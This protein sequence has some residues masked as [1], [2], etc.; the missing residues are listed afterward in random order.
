ML[1]RSSEI[2]WRLKK[3][4]REWKVNRRSHQEF[5]G[6]K[7]RCREDRKRCVAKENLLVKEKDDISMD[8]EVVGPLM[9]TACMS[10][11]LA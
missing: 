7:K 8:D 6:K 4:K 9:W 2:L 10:R 5:S 11:E 1:F 3:A